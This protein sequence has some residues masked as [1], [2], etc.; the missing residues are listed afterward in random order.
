MARMGAMRRAHGTSFAVVVLHSHVCYIL[1]VRMP[2]GE[3][4]RGLEETQLVI[5]DDFMRYA[6]PRNMQRE[7]PP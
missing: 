5:A 2:G 7:P 1:T 3:G 4:R 6:E